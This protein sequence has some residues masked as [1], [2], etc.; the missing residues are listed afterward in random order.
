MKLRTLLLRSSIAWLLFM[1]FRLHARNG[2]WLI[3][4]Y[5]CAR[6]TLS[7]AAH[8][9]IRLLQQEQGCI[10]KHCLCRCALCCCEGN[11]KKQ[12]SPA[13]SLANKS[14]DIGYTYTRPLAT[15]DH[16]AYFSFLSSFIP[17]RAT[18]RKSESDSDFKC[19]R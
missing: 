8:F 2:N 7:P 13:F 10:N 19:L 1:C 5:A 9:H 14:P 3:F 11:K 17:Y 6:M 12:F 4:E 15:I 18:G 16:N